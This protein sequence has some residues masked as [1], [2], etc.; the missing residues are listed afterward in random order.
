MMYYSLKV[1]NDKV[2]A[3]ADGI[4]NF[5]MIRLRPGYTEG[6]LQHE[7]VHV[8]QFWSNPIKDTWLRAFSQKY[9]CDSEIPA[10]KKQLEYPPYSESKHGYIVDDFAPAISRASGIPV[11]EIVRLLE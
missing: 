9:M 5:W 6:Q 3:G 4:T 10:Y 1:T 11:E 7:L 8:G 2:P